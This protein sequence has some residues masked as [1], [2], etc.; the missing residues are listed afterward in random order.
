MKLQLP[1]T[2][3]QANVTT[4]SQ[5]LLRRK[6]Y[7][8]LPSLEQQ[9]QNMVNY[10]FCLAVQ[11]ARLLA[12]WTHHQW[13]LDVIWWHWL[14]PRVLRP[15][16]LTQYSVS[17]HS[18]SRH[19]F[20]SVWH[21]VLHACMIFFLNPQYNHQLKGSWFQQLLYP[22]PPVLMFPSVPL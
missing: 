14:V 20:T 7:V 17:V 5:M 15:C 6:W 12:K 2:R 13:M 11:L 1:G 4:R 19:Y 22:Q 9:R 10:V 16:T 18:L 21:Y 8:S 3:L